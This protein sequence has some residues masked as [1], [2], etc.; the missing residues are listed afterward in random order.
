[1]NFECL[2]LKNS[3]RT[4]DD[5]I[6][7][8]FLVPVLQRTKIYKR[9][10]GFF[11]S[12]ALIE[13]SKGISGLVNNNGKMEL[14]VSPKL[15]DEDI[16]AIEQG[17]EKKEEIIEKSLMDGLSEK[18]EI[19]TDKDRLNLMIDL[20]AKNILDIKVAVLDTN[21]SFGMYHEKIGIMIDTENNMIAFNGSYNESLNSYVNNFE[22]LDVYCSL[23]GEFARVE[24]KNTYFDKMWNNTTNKLQVIDMPDAIKNEMLEVIYDKNN[25]LSEDEIIHK[26]SKNK[27]EVKPYLKREM[28]RPYQKEAI[29][30]WTKNGYRG[31]FDMATGT[32]KTF[33]ALG[34]ATQLYN[35]LNGNLAIIIICPYTHLVEQWAEDLIKFGFDPIVGYG[36]S[37]DRHWKEKLENKTLLYKLESEK[38]KYFCFITTNA[39]FKRPFI[40]EKLKTIE[41]KN[42]LFIADEAHNLGAPD[43]LSKLNDNFKYRIAL[44]ATFD[45][46]NDEEGTNLITKYFSPI[47]NG[48][49]YCIHYSLKQAIEDGKLTEYR[50][51]PVLTYL[52]ED[53][54]Y[55]YI[56]LT[57]QL[58]KY[59]KKDKNG[60]LKLSDSA[61]YILLKRAKLVSGSTDKLPK[62]LN[63]IKKQYKEE[64]GIFN[65]LIYCGATTINDP[66][67]QE[68]KIDNDDNK[69]IN[70]VKDIIK[71]EFNKKNIDLNIARF[72]SLEDN[73]MRRLIK[74]QFCSKEINIIT[75]I[76]CL[77]EGV[78]IPAIKTA[79][80]LASST[81]PREYVQRRGRVLRT[82]DG[83]DYAEIYDFITLPR[84]LD[85]AQH[86]ERGALISDIGLVKRELAR[87]MDFAE[88]ASNYSEIYDIIEEINDVYGDII[89]ETNYMEDDF[90]N[91]L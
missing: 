91:E 66:S 2:T 48:N 77:D 36:D 47:N 25:V 63:L 4:S 50:Y 16:K 56:D 65:T 18:I 27:H 10:A 35:D 83:K 70:I 23:K 19:D 60:K 22:S 71:E 12:T 21:D 82:F 89:T 3:Y 6:I 67:Y 40:Q 29:D 9:A 37:S 80:I 74:E 88:T 26:E 41:K 72:T 42:I 51:H 81:N 8:D 76:K 1:M 20:I 61:K 87:I 68:N 14:I 5:N 11:S 30:N 39:S 46:Y 53:E 17:Y 32:V 52:N 54:L 55:D 33:T 34:A 90:N 69:Q 78:N 13:L 24:E 75:A 79:Y 57:N 38:D 59:M 7:E 15:S 58:R 73:K 86:I 64:N 28:L 31:I 84:H 43:L 49:P 45:R 44:S 85:E 62:L